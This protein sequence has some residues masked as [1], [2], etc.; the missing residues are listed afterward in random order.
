MPH[1]KIKNEKLLCSCKNGWSR[2][3]DISLQ[4]DLLH[5]LIH[6]EPSLGRNNVGKDTLKV[7]LL[8]SN[9]TVMIFLEKTWPFMLTL[10]IEELG[11]FALS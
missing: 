11:F 5:C 3:P 10:V 9:C 6:R 1:L 4:I 2:L 8:R 7:T